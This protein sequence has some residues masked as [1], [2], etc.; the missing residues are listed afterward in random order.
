MARITSIRP[1][2]AVKDLP[3]TIAFYTNDLG[4]SCTA[5]FGEPPVWCTLVRDGQE[6]MFNAPP[7]EDVE[8]DVPM[9]SRDYQI[10]Y[11]T[12]DDIVGF[13][14]MLRSRG[15]SVSDLR[16]TVYQMKEFDLRDPDNYWLMFGQGTDDVP[17]VCE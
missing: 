16:V 15:L 6:I 10:F 5:T 11:V 8:R 13:H 12:T 1:M 3:R 9:R 4:F 17:T 2:L 14:S 7:R